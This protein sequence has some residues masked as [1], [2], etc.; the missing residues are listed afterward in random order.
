MRRRTWTEDSLTA[1]CFESTQCSSLVASRDQMAPRLR[2]DG[3]PAPSLRDMS[4]EAPADTSAMIAARGH[5]DTIAIHPIDTKAVLRADTSAMRL[6]DTRATPA[7]DL[8]TVMDPSA[9][10]TTTIVVR[11]TQTGG[12]SLESERGIAKAMVATVVMGMPRAGRAARCNNARMI[13]IMVV[14]MRIGVNMRELQG[15]ATLH[16]PRVDYLGAGASANA[17]R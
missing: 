14:V 13:M 4:V 15:L 10:M 8:A 17:S 16:T 12:T 3:R 5:R 7:L 11:M 6:I 9:M 1:I 2:H